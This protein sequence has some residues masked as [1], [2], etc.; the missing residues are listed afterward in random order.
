MQEQHGQI[1]H[2][3]IIIQLP[4]PVSLFLCLT[5][6]PRF[7][8]LPSEVISAPNGKSGIACSDNIRGTLGRRANGYSGRQFNAIHVKSAQGQWIPTHGNVMPLNENSNTQRQQQTT[9][10]QL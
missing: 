3:A 2:T 9:T 4:A 10:A 7:L 1:T 6:I 5:P 8:V